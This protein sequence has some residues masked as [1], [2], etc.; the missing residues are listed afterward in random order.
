M[1]LTAK[2]DVAFPG[3]NLKTL[4]ITKQ[5][6]YEFL[7]RWAKH[8]RHECPKRLLDQKQTSKEKKS[9]NKSTGRR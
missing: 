9:R 4:Q 5:H 1:L 8:H 2:L 3:S 6:Q 7:A